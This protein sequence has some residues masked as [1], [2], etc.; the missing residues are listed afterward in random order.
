MKKGTGKFWNVKK[1]R[2]KSF[3]PQSETTKKIEKN[4]NNNKSQSVVEEQ[5]VT[6][7]KKQL[8]KSSFRKTHFEESKSNI[9]LAKVSS[10]IVN[11]NKKF[12]SLSL[13]DFNSFINSPKKS[14]V[15]NN[16][17]QVG[18]DKRI[19]KS[20][21]NFQKLDDI[22]LSSPQ[23]KNKMFFSL[24]NSKN[25]HDKSIYEKNH[26]IEHL[27]E[28]SVCKNSDNIFRP[29]S[30][31]MNKDQIEKMLLNT[32][33]Q[34]KNA[35]PAYIENKKFTKKL[36]KVKGGTQS[37]IKDVEKKPKNLLFEPE[38]KNIDHLNFDGKE[39]DKLFT[40]EVNQNNLTYN[41]T[42]EQ[43]YINQ[44]KIHV[45]NELESK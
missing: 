27:K 30:C 9:K 24:V 4:I 1:L 39:Y 14:K 2:R 6:I 15:V 32:K 19:T 7:H 11:S 36:H 41:E 20:F 8:N 38:D 21:N 23:S 33:E 34:P 13:V 29:E 17:S 22:N 43:N 26:E 16:N 10:S 28:T 18:G 42:E 44:V 3:Q 25:T 35:F 37:F 45:F 40:G 12:K 5:Q 31:I